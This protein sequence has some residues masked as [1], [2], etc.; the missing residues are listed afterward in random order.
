[1]MPLLRHAP[2]D[3]LLLGGEGSLT[4]GQFLHQAAALA[5]T[6]PANP[7]VINVCES[8]HAFMLGF[9]AALMRG[10]VSLLPPGRGADDLELVLR[11]FPDA[12][13]LTDVPSGVTA[14]HIGLSVDVSTFMKLPGTL[15]K[16][17]DLDPA[18]TA[19]I[20]FTSGSTGQPAAHAKTW[21]ALCRGADALSN[22]LGWQHGAPAAI[23]GSVP[24]Q[25]MF[26]LETTVLLPWCLGIAVHGDKP[27]LPTDLECALREC[28]RVT[29]WMTTPA[30]L[31]SHLA[32][33]VPLP[34]LQSVVAS[35]MSL[36]QDQAMLAEGAWKVPVLE[37][38]G[39]T[40]TGALATRRTAGETLWTPLAGVSLDLVD[41][42]GAFGVR[43]SAPHIP[44]PVVLADELQLEADGR[45]RWLRRAGD[46]VKVGGKRGS[47][48]ALTRQLLA[49]PG[50]EDGV[51]FLPAHQDGA[52]T[53]RLA[54]F[55]VSATLGPS[56][57]LKL[58]R[59]HVDAVFLPR[60]LF[61]VP[62][63]PRNA[64][65]K[66][67][68]QALTALLA[69]CRAEAA[70]APTANIRSVRFSVP[71]THPAL[72]AHFP[73]NPIVP[74]A[75]IIARA[76][77][78]F[79]GG[80]QFNVG[81]LTSARFHAPLRPDIDCEVM[82]QIEAVGGGLRVRFEIH[83]CDTRLLIASGTWSCATSES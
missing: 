15:L 24:P 19:A 41:R 71:A 21:G 32:S 75:V 23:V 38:Y 12:C 27:L 50:I 25:H 60:P 14:A 74:G 65:G 68:V 42:D 22:A 54:A 1:M 18:L 59:E 6:L 58:L 13:I 45:F 81:P 63:L 53:G 36:P 34:N 56:E 70:N 17:P 10:S 55:Y 39:A 47:L 64:N 31:R 20:L 62:A 69:H 28:G 79:N 2:Q 26:G 11:R 29:C 7:H 83:E 57:V 77:Q 49:L 48:L 35:T 67:P 73:G 76:A 61:R 37:I 40:E 78:L 4:A 44:E 80:Q 16:V 30:H 9:A 66:L 46:I 3:V 33:P 51:C 43:A 8:R 72:P 82:Y 52:D 5:R